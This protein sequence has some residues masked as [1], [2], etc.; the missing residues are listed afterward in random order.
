MDRR[1]RSC[2]GGTKRT[3]GLCCA[4]T[5]GRGRRAPGGL[6]GSE[7][8]WSMVR[9]RSSRRRRA[10]VVWRCDAQNVQADADDV[11]GS[12]GVARARRSGSSAIAWSAADGVA[13]LSSGDPLRRFLRRPGERVGVPRG[14]RPSGWA[15]RAARR[16]VRC[17]RR[18]SR[19][20]ASIAREPTGAG[21]QGDVCDGRRSS[22]A[23]D[24]LRDRVPVHHARGEG[25]SGR[26]RDRGAVQ[27]SQAAGAVHDAGPGLRRSRFAGL[28][29]GQGLL[30][31][32]RSVHRDRSWLRL[33]GRRR[34]CRRRA[35]RCSTTRP[36]A[37]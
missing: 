27:R 36:G 37:C 18:R 2:R 9:G 25:V 11:A 28:Q 1:S 3:G 22:R 35:V 5:T 21:P 26:R 10:V 17:A 31:V 6:R 16:A 12:V 32:R 30:A 19:T 13:R 8:A 34:R 4:E 7:R 33:D 24:G 14:V 20:S 29:A 15:L 23:R